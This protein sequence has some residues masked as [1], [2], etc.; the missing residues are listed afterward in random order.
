MKRALCHVQVIFKKGGV[1]VFPGNSRLR[2]DLGGQVTRAKL[3]AT[4]SSR[5]GD[6]V[7]NKQKAVRGGRDCGEGAGEISMETL[8]LLQWVPSGIGTGQVLG[9]KSAWHGHGRILA[10]RTAR[11]V[12]E[13]SG[14]LFST[15]EK[16]H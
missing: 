11:S 13:L 5:D 16:W 1:A 2:G 12:V 8:N 10:A 4:S 14:L 7:Y 15:Q 6:A 3:R 9:K